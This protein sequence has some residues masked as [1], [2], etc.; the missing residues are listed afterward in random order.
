MEKNTLTRTHQFTLF[1]ILLSIGL[2]LHY[3]E[4]FLSIPVAGFLLKIGLSNVVIL[5]YL[6]QNK[7]S[8]AILMS[9]CKLLLALFFSPTINFS[10]FLIS[11]GGAIASL[12]VM[13][14]VNKLLKEKII[15]VS[16]C[17][18]IFHNL[19]QLGAVLF[20]VPIPLPFQ[21]IS[22]LV[23]LLI[24]LGSLTGFMVGSITNLIL[25]KLSNI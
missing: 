14:L 7:T 24:I 9:M 25:T 20:L 19:G 12:F 17:G 15:I 11:L 23:P 5:Y 22:Y 2:T 4:S 18:G 10:N 16:I 13:L 6:I 8:E 21:Q 3:L 1:A